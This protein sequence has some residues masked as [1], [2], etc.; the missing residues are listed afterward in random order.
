MLRYL[1]GFFLI[2]H[3]AI[4][5]LGA[6]LAWGIADYERLDN[7]PWFDMPPWMV[8]VWGGVW[9]AALL[10]LAAAGVAVAVGRTWWRAVATVG[11][12]VSSIAIIPYVPGAGLGLV[13]NIIVV[14]VLV[15]TDRGVLDLPGSPQPAG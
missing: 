14:V 1:V 2:L 12:V 6:S 3:A 15:E 10:I 11:L 7:D 13:A 5:W 9:M 8:K 4:H